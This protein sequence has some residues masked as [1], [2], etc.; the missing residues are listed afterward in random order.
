MSVTFTE[1]KAL[2]QYIQYLQE[3]RARLLVEYK[4][5]MVRL[6][7]LDEL[8]NVHPEKPIVEKVEEKIVE[9]EKPITSLEDAISAIQDL[10]GSFEEEEVDPKYAREKEALKDLDNRNKPIKSRSNQDVKKVTQAAVSILKEAGIP[11]KTSKL[12]SMLKEQG[13]RINSPYSMMAQIRG[14]EPRIT[15]ASH[16]YYQYKY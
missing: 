4:G 15:Q 14:Y 3:E 12:M 9:N 1:R 10:N 5:A 8:D 13:F 6:S 16:G 7:K 11:I 2:E